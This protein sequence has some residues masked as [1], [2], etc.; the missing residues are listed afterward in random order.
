MNPSENAE[1]KRDSGKPS[2]SSVRKP[3]DPRLLA[4]GGLVVFMLFALYMIWPSQPRL[5]EIVLVAKPAENL[6]TAENP[7]VEI[8]TTS[9][10]IRARLF[11]DRAP[12]TVQNFV[13]LVNQ[14]FY[15]GI[16]FHR[17]IPGFMIQ[18]GDPRGNGTGGRQDRG[19]EPKVLQDEFDPSLRHDRPGLLSMANKGPNTGD[20]QFFI[21]TGPASHLDDKHAIFGEVIDGM[22]VVKEIEGV[23]TDKRNDMPFAPPRM[24]KVHLLSA[25]ELT[26]K[27]ETDASSKGESK[28]AVPEKSEPLGTPK[29]E[30]SN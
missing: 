13:E 30:K 12:E 6:P 5:R 1:V 28:N 8:E 24:I 23:P 7:I 20:C 2:S 17:V 10:K 27:A 19:L 16:V 21:T 11:R 15:D 26:K 3:T 22:Q 18:T 29:V 9:G 14:G 4:V 25:D